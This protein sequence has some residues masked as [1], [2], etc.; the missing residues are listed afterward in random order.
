MKES[1]IRLEADKHWDYTA[2]MMKI[3]YVEAYIHGFK[4]GKEY[5]LLNKNMREEI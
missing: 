3:A 4:H 5:K 2:K 1:E